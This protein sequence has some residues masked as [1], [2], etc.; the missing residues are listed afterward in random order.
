[1]PHRARTR[2]PDRAPETPASARVGGYS[3]PVTSERWDEGRIRFNVG[4]GV[5]G[6]RDLSDPGRAEADVDHCLRAIR[7][8]FAAPETN[9]T[10]TVISAL[11]EGADRLVVYRAFDVFGEAATLHA[12]LPLAPDEYRSDFASYD[13]KREFDVLL[14]KAAD[15]HPTRGSDDRDEAYERAGRHIVDHSDVVIA[16]WNGDR[17]GGRGGTGQIVEY[18]EEHHVPVFVIPSARLS[19][20]DRAPVP[21]PKSWRRQLGRIADRPPFTR[22]AQLNKGSIS[23]PPLG[24]MAEEMWSRLEE[25]AQGSSVPWQEVAAWFVPRLVRADAL[26]VKY[27]KWYHRMDTAVYAL[28][29]LAVAVVAVQSQA[30]WSNKVLLAE[31]GC[32]L[33]LVSIYGIARTLGLHERWIGYRSLAENVRSALFIALASALAEGAGLVRVVDQPWFQRAFSEV[34]SE[35]PASPAIT[36]DRELQQF[37]IKGWAEDQARYHRKTVKRLARQRRVLTITL[38]TLFGLTLVAGLLH[39]FDALSG[40]SA[41]KTLVVLA[42]V[43]PAAGAALTGIR[44]QR[45]YRLHEVRSTRAADRLER[46]AQA[47]SQDE[48]ET[49]PRLAEQI[50]TVIRAEALDWSGVIE[51]QDIDLVT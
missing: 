18:A 35:R 15:R 38:L 44:D 3:R 34:W 6:H 9:V 49:A 21:R 27:E 14:D 28:A 7:D 1:L 10:F 16:L 41:E 30:G 13:S 4:V 37:L 23:H 48:T 31:V 43:L 50:N 2:K 33:A 46:L 17:G 24:P 12:V 45:Q 32:M 39:V 5:T 22:V 36:N 20:R 25:A 8:A 47:H 51:F 42:I 26:A 11:A 29:A 40:D 19:E